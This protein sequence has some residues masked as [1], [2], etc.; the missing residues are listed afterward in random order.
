MKKQSFFDSI[1]DM[2]IQIEELEKLIKQTWDYKS[3]EERLI[4][5]KSSLNILKKR[6]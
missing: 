4:R 5:L 6:F 1:D 3:L 2:A